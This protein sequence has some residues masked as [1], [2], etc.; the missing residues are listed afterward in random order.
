MVPGMDQGV[1]A[2]GRR[3]EGGHDSEMR[4][5]DTATCPPP[6]KLRSDDN[7]KEEGETGL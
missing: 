4:H 2:C 6:P 7:L 1:W 3:I 5:K